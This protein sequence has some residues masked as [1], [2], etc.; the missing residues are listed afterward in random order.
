MYVYSIDCLYDGFI[1]YVYEIHD[2]IYITYVV[3]IYINNIYINFV[4]QRNN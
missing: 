1:Q 4:I 3:Y 2:V